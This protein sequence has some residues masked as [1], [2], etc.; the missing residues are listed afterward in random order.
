M[1]GVDYIEQYIGMAREKCKLILCMCD[2]DSSKYQLQSVAIQL[3]L[4][5]YKGIG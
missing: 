5:G 2:Q 3:N 4:L 1:G